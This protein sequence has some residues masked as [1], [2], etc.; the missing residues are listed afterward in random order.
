MVHKCLKCGAVYDDD[1]ESIING[2]PKCGSVFFMYIKDEKDVK[3]FEKLQKDIKEKR[4]D[5]KKEVVK[6]K[7]GV[8]TIRI[9][10]DGVYEINIDA[11]LKGEPLI[12]LVKNGTYFVYLPSVFEKFEK[13]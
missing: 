7:F 5:L 4:I 13:K 1:D 2:C 8:E 12:V 3:A 10:K 11:L 9:P 6:S